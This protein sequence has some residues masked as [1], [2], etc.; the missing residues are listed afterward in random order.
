MV[1][2]RVGVRLVAEGGRIVRAEMQGLGAAGEK[3]F[4]DINRSARTAASGADAFDASI[5]QTRRGLGGYQGQVQNAA[6]QIGDFAVQVGAG[7]AA[8]TAL[9]Q[10][11]PQLLGGFG[12]LGAVM[13]AVVAVAIPLGRAFLSSAD[14]AKTLTEANSE[15]EAS[16]GRL[17]DAN[18]VY[19]TEGLQG[20]IDRYGELNAEILLLIERQQQFAMA[21]ALVAAKAAASTLTGELSGVLSNLEAYEAYMNADSSDPANLVQAQDYAQ[22][23]QEEFGLTI[24]QAQALQLAIDAAM[25][26]NSPEAMARAMAT[27]T[28]VIEDSTLAGTDFAGALLQAESNLRALNAEAGGIGGWLGAAISGTATWA[29]GLWD[30]AAAARAAAMASATGGMTGTTYAAN[31]AAASGPAGGPAYVAPEPPTRPQSRP[32]GIDFGYVPAT[33]VA[34]S[35]SGGA[36]QS[37][38]D[39]AEAAREAVDSILEDVAKKYEQAGKRGADAISDMLMGIVDGSKSARE[40]LGDLLS[41]LAQVQLQRGILGLGESGGFLGGLFQSLGGALGTNATGTNYWKGGLT[42]VGERGPEIVNLPRGAQVLDAN[43]SKMAGG[44]MVDVR[45]FVDQDGNW[46]AAVERISMGAAAKTVQQYDGQ[47]Y[48]NARATSGDRRRVS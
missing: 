27:I 28:G 29:A 37:V 4:S 41:Q 16:L 13:G 3:A 40:A 23:I 18:E 14:G 19:S 48:Q 42:W 38:V 21:E 15:L 22:A 24:L 17:Q 11:L 44:G 35:P 2:K 45:V 39:E 47:K 8:S 43:R 26:T 12:I 25:G 33:G 30:A 1:E 32:M 5:E 46:Q 7:T 9:A 34:G 36:A 6:F 31:T 10:Q 20:V